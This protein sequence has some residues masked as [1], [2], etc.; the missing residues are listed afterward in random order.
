MSVRYTSDTHLCTP[1]AIDEY[2][3]LSLEGL[4]PGFNIPSITK[5]ITQADFVSVLSD[6]LY[7]HIFTRYTELG[8]KEILLT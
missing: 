2:N 3:E 1:Q 5:M 7:T 6:A 8:L 4:L